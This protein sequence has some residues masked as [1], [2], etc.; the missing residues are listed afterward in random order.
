M[1]VDVMLDWYA[2]GTLDD[3]VVDTGDMPTCPPPPPPC[4]SAASVT[5]VV[6]YPVLVV[7]GVTRTPLVDA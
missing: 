6:P 5:V 7:P 4:C 3:V 2:D 1:A